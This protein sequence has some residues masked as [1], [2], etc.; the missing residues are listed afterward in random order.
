MKPAAFEYYDPTTLSEVTALL[1]RLGEDARVLA[2]GQSLVPLMNFRLARPAHLVDLNRVAELDHLSVEGGELR[3]GAMTRQRTL[4]R[5][6]EVAAGWP[7]LREAAGF[8]GHVQIRNRGTVGGS[9]AHAYPS[10]E[11]PVAM[12][13]LDAALVVQGEDGERTVAAEEFFLG[14]MTTVLEP[15]ELL[16]EV[17]V[18]AVLHGSGAS[19]KE[20]SR[21]Y[22]DFALAGAAALVTLDHD[23]AMAGARLTLTG[24]A[25]I[26]AR[27]AEDAVVGEK[28]SEA[29][30]R[31]AAR[32]AV[33]GI[34][35]DSDMHASAEYRRRACEALA[36]RALTEA[37][38]RA[39][40]SFEEGSS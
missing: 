27:A 37:A 5:S 30:F 14:T 40:A 21:R 13:A 16:R 23:G 7:L 11:L 18:P 3:I 33:D 12:V 24:S 1:S 39:A 9:L 36:R 6:D 10:A 38:R 29:L 2:G 17:R 32:R 35:Q 4:E 31:E 20:V 26:R 19:F 8:I 34:E 15:G 28:P 25:P 22:G